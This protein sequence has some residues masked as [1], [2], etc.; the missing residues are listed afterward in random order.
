MQARSWMEK[1]RKYPKWKLSEL[2]DYSGPMN[3]RVF[4]YLDALSRPEDPYSAIGYDRDRKQLAAEP[5]SKV[6]ERTEIARDFAKHVETVMHFNGSRE[7][8][9]KWEWESYQRLDK[10]YPHLRVMAQIENEKRFKDI[11]TAQGCVR[12]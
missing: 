9:L 3:H 5:E 4:E 12:S 6:N 7:D 10:K 1:L 2:G 11:K 8:R